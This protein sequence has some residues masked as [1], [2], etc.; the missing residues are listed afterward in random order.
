[1]AGREAEGANIH[2]ASFDGGLGTLLRERSNIAA[3]RRD[4]WGVPE[5]LAE[6]AG[7]R[8]VDVHLDARHVGLA[9]GCRY[10]GIAPACTARGSVGACE[11][12]A[13]ADVAAAVVFVQAFD[14]DGVFADGRVREMRAVHVVGA[15]VALLG[16]GAVGELGSQAIVVEDA[17]DAGVAGV[18]ADRRGV[19][20][21]GGVGLRALGAG[22]G[23]AAGWAR[24]AKDICLPTRS[25]PAR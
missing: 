22:V 6:V 8:T 19:L 12:L 23:G 25:R 1:M 7:I 14:A 17:T 5:P 15:A 16:V 2:R 18:I 3:I 13:V 9:L 21:G 4:L 11:V 10:T 20:A 24:A